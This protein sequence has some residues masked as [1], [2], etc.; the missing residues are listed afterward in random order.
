MGTV[1]DP[2]LDRLR[3]I[4]EAGN[5]ARLPADTEPVSDPRLEKLRALVEGESSAPPLPPT[6]QDVAAGHAP[7]APMPG[8]ATATEFLRPE[9]QRSGLGGAVLGSVIA[10]A[11][12]GTVDRAL[13][14]KKGGL[15]EQVRER[16][17]PAVLAIPGR[18]IESPMS[19]GNPDPLAGVPT[20]IPSGEEMLQGANLAGKAA[21]ELLYMRMFGPLFEGLLS[22]PGRIMRG[23]GFQAIPDAVGG[24][25]SRAGAAATDAATT[26]LSDAARRGAA[27]LTERGMEPEAA[28]RLAGQVAGRG[29]A[30]LRSLPEGA[31][32]GAAFTA[33][34]D[35]AEG[36]D[37]TPEGLAFGAGAGGA[38][39]AALS[40]AA[41]RP[42]GLG[43]A[44]SSPVQATGELAG[45]YQTL[46]V[47]EG[48]S[49]DDVKAAYR[50]AAKRFHPDT[51]PDNPLAADQFARASS[52][53][54]TILTERMGASTP[55][56]SEPVRAAR[57][58][59]SEAPRAAEKPSAA[60]PPPPA[61]VD[62]AASAKVASGEPVVVGAQ[63]RA[64]GEAPAPDAPPP[65]VVQ[66]APEAASVVPEPIG[67]P[68]SSVAAP[69]EPEEA[70]QRVSSDPEST[71]APAPDIADARRELNA[72]E[73]KYQ[74]PGMHVLS[75]PKPGT[76][77]F[78]EDH[79][80]IAELREALRLQPWQRTQA[81]VKGAWDMPA[82]AHRKQVERA[83]AQGKP[84]PPE[85]LAEYPD[86]QPSAAPPPESQ[87]ENRPRSEVEP[88]PPSSNGPLAEPM[89]G[90]GTRPAV[91]EPE[92]R[93][94]AGRLTPLSEL[95]RK[96]IRAAWDG[97]VAVP[98]ADALTD[99][100]IL[101]LKAALTPKAQR[102]AARKLLTLGAREKNAK[103]GQVVSQDSLNQVSNLPFRD[104]TEPVEV[105][106]VLDRSEDF[107]THKH[108]RRVILASVGGAQTHLDADQ[109][110]LLRELTD[111]DQLTRDPSPGGEYRPIVARRN[112]EPVG[113]ITPLS[114]LTPGSESE[115]YRVERTVAPPAD[116][117]RLARQ[118][119]EVEAHAERDGM[120]AR[121]QRAVR[122]STPRGRG[123][124]GT[125][126]ERADQVASPPPPAPLARPADPLR[127]DA[128]QPI[129]A[130]MRGR[131]Q[132]PPRP[133][134]GKPVS[135]P[136]VMWSFSRIAKAAGKEIPMRVG[137]LG[138]KS[139]RGV[140]KIGPEVIRILEANDLPTA[141]HEVAHAVEKILFGWPKGGP[142]VNPRVDRSIQR[143]LLQMGRDLY[144][145]HAPNGGYKREGWAEYVR[146]WLT[147]EGEAQAKA[148]N[149][150]KWFDGAFSTEFPKVRKSL[151]EARDL[152]TRWRTQ[153]SRA[154]AAQS[155]VDTAAPA[156]RAKGLTRTLR[157]MV[158]KEQLLDMAEPFRRLSAAAGERGH[159][160]TPS[161]DPYVTISALR[162][163]HSARARF[164]VEHG[165]IDLA[166][167]VTGPA[168]DDIRALVKGRREDFTLY[169]WARRAEK[170][171]LD[172]EGPRSP[173]LSLED[174]QQILRELD[175]PEFELAAGKVYEWSDGVLDYA[176]QASPTFAEAV[177]K[178]RAR[179]PGDYVPLLRVF[180]E[181]DQARARLSGGGASAARGSLTKRLKG[182]G[183][184]IKDPFQALVS[185]AE[186]TVRAAHERLVI[187]QILKLS[188]VEGL[189]HLME[190]VPVEG[191][192]AT[193]VSVEQLVDR[194]SREVKDAGGSLK[195]DGDD[196]DLAGRALTFFAPV[197]R[198]GGKDAI[199][200]IWDG[201]A[202]RWFQVDPE[203]Y[204]ALG[205]LD[206]YRISDTLGL[207]G[208]VFIETPAQIFRAGTTGLRA[209]FGLLWN[210]TRDLQTLYLN[211]RVG[212][213][214]HTLLAAYLRS[215]GD[216]ALYRTTG[217][218]NPYMDAFVRLGGEMAQPLGQDI[219]H[220]R[221]AAHRLFQ[222]RL[223]RT[224]DPHNWFDTFRDL[225]QTPEAAPRV[226][227]LRLKA[228]EVGWQPGEPMTLDQSL[229]LLLAAKQVTTDFTAAGELA[230]VLNRMA[231]F[232]NA[233]IQGPRATLRA[234]RGRPGRFALRG[235]ELTAATLLLW[236][237]QKDEDWYKEMP[238]NERFLNW[239]F[240]FD[241][242]GKK[243]L[244]RLPRAF[245]VGSVFSALPE[246]MADAWYREDP[247][248]ATAWFQTFVDASVPNPTPVLLGETFEQ[249]AN[250]DFFWDRPIVPRGEEEKPE[251][252]QFNEYTSRAAIA[253]GRTFGASPRRVDHAIQGLFGP[254]GGDLLSVLGL[255]AK[256]VEREKE[257]ADLP[258][259]GRAFQRGGAMGS[260]LRSVEQLYDALEKA[261]LRQGSDEHPET[262]EERQM[263]LQL[264][265]ATRAVAALS[266][267]RGQT[268][269]TDTRAKLTGEIASLAQDAVRASDAGELQRGRFLGARRLAEIRKDRA[270]KEAEARKRLLQPRTIPGGKGPAYAEPPTR[271]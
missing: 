107:P 51:N 90:Q 147:T 41:G 16:T 44:V 133:Q 138:T 143:E 244:L 259:V 188:R 224:V 220:T 89:P 18:T 1:V 221:R 80:R 56:P 248:A 160:M 255:G 122:G 192:P 201:G 20:H 162:M 170:L 2:R 246:L 173:G 164:M 119:Q 61:A 217:R 151:D 55:A 70:P 127:P 48:A 148:P 193:V 149:L 216:A 99:R 179:D 14:G 79:A 271:R 53:Y 215:M 185:K 69:I 62:E 266:Y 85:V 128:E 251:E 233:A 73:A 10:G 226:A 40:A 245:E 131:L 76:E 129:S 171:W 159:A 212:A 54:Q 86:L 198:P 49:L 256:G 253:L 172:P 24:A 199:V 74:G 146:M 225:V 240:A 236:W 195:V 114:E 100:H 200:P 30:A 36:D 257:L 152:A 190:E 84:V 218:R 180:E 82:A 27:F 97:N 59:R 267:V 72:I 63:R 134:K 157:S 103:S 38:L 12:P 17:D 202:M 139:A 23:I 98:E 136:Q 37:V 167:N 154:R 29:L 111:F 238:F 11:V 194:L 108:P 92:S 223:L 101:V 124:M 235:L 32:A 222:G 67:A 265:D 132:A 9:D 175:S 142:W 58:P 250:R 209:S 141:A 57:R 243:Q 239:H 35:L 115:R 161:E 81:Q 52:A 64:P 264:E 118:R 22:A 184:R 94:N 242:N 230:R 137:R 156:E 213:R 169:L 125:P 71:S 7:P 126:K 93:Q 88:A 66:A 65:V 75:A 13:T 181:L 25:A 186:A 232:F 77:Q 50:A 43:T 28:S 174:A 268:G 91:A 68:E 177:A 46:G 183:R 6:I 234:A 21:K 227:E 208:K 247:E 260:R 110:H 26:H 166:G 144:G 112:G 269:A 158:S 187:E 210:P 189:G 104:Y 106:G 145:D 19:M 196:V 130:D 191:A 78:N 33:L 204:H 231:P 163:T 31:G 153:G 117:E 229:Q 87:A 34:H 228:D 203:L 95:R 249:L 197:Q 207:L 109:V 211:S 42:I 261:K 5:G 270:L 8:D 123:R 105:L 135:G 182:S 116:T 60:P 150:T 219:P 155:M 113:L 83:L 176:A 241:W 237:S 120:D 206:V 252:E 263:R 3:S 262:R 15:Q 168:L 39:G 205:T 214:P 4:V 102:G 47:R 258:V 96:S 45:A 165:M 140:F 254:V 121:M 178:I